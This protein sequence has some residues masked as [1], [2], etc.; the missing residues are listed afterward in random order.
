MVM[1]LYENDVLNENEMAI[2]VKQYWKLAVITVEE[3][4]ILNKNFRSKLFNSP[5][6]RREA[7]NIV[8]DVSEP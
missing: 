6:E 8:F 2:L 7:A 3:D 1:K 4:Q 5:D